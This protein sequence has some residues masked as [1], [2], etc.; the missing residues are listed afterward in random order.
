M[1]VQITDKTISFAA[2]LLGFIIRQTIPEKRLTM[3]KET[4]RIDYY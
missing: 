1:S 3:T 2:F 4:R